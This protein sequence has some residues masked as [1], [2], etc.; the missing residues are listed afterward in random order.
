[1]I[2]NDFLMIFF[3]LQNRTFILDFHKLCFIN[4]TGWSTTTRGFW[5]FFCSCVDDSLSHVPIASVNIDSRII[6]LELEKARLESQL[7][8]AVNQDEFLALKETL[9]DT[10]EAQTSY[11]VN[12]WPL[13]VL[14]AVKAKLLQ[15]RTYFILDV[16]VGSVMFDRCALFGNT[17]RRLLHVLT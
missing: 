8:T 12:R 5:F 9:E 14:L 2:R 15:K 6:E 17:L 10:K 11:K 1:M 7:S 4:N 13:L 16:A 3:I